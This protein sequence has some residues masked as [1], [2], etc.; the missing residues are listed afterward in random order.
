MASAMMAAWLD[1][2]PEVEA[3][4]S[5]WYFR[6]HIPERVTLPGF[7]SGRRY[8]SHGGG[9]NKYLALYEGVAKEVFAS[10]A[11]RER[12][13]VPTEW[14][15]RIMPH[16]RNFARS[17]FDVRF[18]LGNQYGGTVA[19][20]R[21]DA[22]GAL[23]TNLAKWLK[24]Q[25]LPALAE[26]SGICRVRLLEGDE[27]QSKPKTQ[28]AQMREGAGGNA[29]APWTVCIESIGIDWL[30]PAMTEMLPDQALAEQGATDIVTGYYDLVFGM[31]NRD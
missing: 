23:G 15:T 28:E 11:Y 21:Y 29:W 13:D 27:D 3:E 5:D 7:L 18:E 26:H 10:E 19:T 30:R 12:L 24:G 8:T 22:P 6:E 16:F 14:T 25:V 4:F 1:I 20:I 17:V 2:T 9:P 31:E